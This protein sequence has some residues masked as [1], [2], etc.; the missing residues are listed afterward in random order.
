MEGQIDKERGFKRRGSGGSNVEE[1]CWLW[2]G[3]QIIM[4]RDEMGE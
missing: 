3:F 2:K 4:R 1:E